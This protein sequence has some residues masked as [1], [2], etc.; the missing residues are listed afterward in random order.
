MRFA[1]SIFS[2]TTLWLLVLS[3]IH[4]PLAHCTEKPFK[5]WMNSFTQ[6]AI[7][8]YGVS[9][10]TANLVNSQVSLQPAVIRLDRS[11]PEFVNT[12][13]KYYESHVSP[14]R[15]V[16]GRK[17]L[18]EYESLLNQLELKYGVSREILIA[19]WGMETNFGT[20]QG[21]IDTVSA[22]AT[23]AYEGRRSTFFKN[24]LIDVMRI[25][26]QQQLPLN[27]LK[28]SWAGA[29]GHMQFMPSTF[30][31]HAVD[32]DDNQSI[33]LKNSVPDAL[34]SAAN[35][36]SKVGWDMNTPTMIEVKL[37][38]NF[39]YQYASI[40]H[41]KTISQWS[42]LGVVA[43]DAKLSDS[44]FARLTSQNKRA[45]YS[46]YD[47]QYV[48]KIIK[49][50]PLVEV[51]DNQKL[52]ASIVLP[53]GWQGPAFMV[54]NNFQTIMDWNRS[55]NYALSVTLLA[56]QLKELTVL[57]AGKDAEPGAL[58]LL[59]MKRLQFM[60][61]QLGFDSGPPDG[62]PGLQTQSAIRAY[63]LSQGLP[64]DGYASPSIYYHL[65]EK[66][67]VNDKNIPLDQ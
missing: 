55:I 42:A 39:S 58:S 43:I 6:E 53:Q 37:P 31:L 23:L 62:Y 65:D 16:N 50:K 64:A 38:E 33:D 19:F 4:V 40:N 56:H 17:K 59:Q 22:L 7:E 12:F 35:Y 49:F 46:D 10:K 25:I 34:T 45:E 61:N 3:L 36:I 11:Q 57:G 13:L 63:Q 52:K 51:I 24:Q 20:Y 32:G 2:K 26:D 66:M 15:V 41:E 5:E 1:K 18:K 8:K 48:D 14:T 60:L 29:F 47:H 30:M 67:I 28:G 44:A 54:F 21:D 27:Y 9:I